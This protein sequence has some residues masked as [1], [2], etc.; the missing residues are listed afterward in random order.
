MRRRP[1]ML[2]PMKPM[3]NAEI[4][5]LIREQENGLRENPEWEE[6]LTYLILYRPKLALE[7]KAAGMLKWADGRARLLRMGTPAEVVFEET[8]DEMDEEEQNPPTDSQREN[9][10]SLEQKLLVHY[11][12]R[13]ADE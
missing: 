5:E 11:G 1:G 2:R 9:L 10:K 4:A 6:A 12:H 3:T 7:L 8:E 13:E